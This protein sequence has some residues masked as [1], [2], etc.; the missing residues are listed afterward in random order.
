MAR[1]VEARYPFLDLEL[2]ELARRV[3]PALKLNHLTEKYL[4]RRMAEERLPRAIVEREK[5]GFRAPGSPGLLR[6]GYEWVEELL[7]P[8]TVRRHGVF[9]PD[10]VAWL[11][12]QYR[13][14]GHELHPHLDTDLLMVVLTSHLL[15]ELFA[16]QGVA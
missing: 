8:E 10:A 14:E 11:A 2:I 12:R 1:S 7:A 13:R 4:V 9:E 3:P 15:C 16:L 5:F 6:R